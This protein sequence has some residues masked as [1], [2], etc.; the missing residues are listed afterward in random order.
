MAPSTLSALVLAV[1]APASASHRAPS[2]APVTVIQ[3]STS[4]ARTVPSS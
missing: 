4:S 2:V 1:M 3:A